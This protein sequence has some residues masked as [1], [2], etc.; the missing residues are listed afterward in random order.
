L[1]LQGSVGG[2]HKKRRTI[3]FPV[4]IVFLREK[5]RPQRGTDGDNIAPQATPHDQD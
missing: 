1:I 5:E 2:C 3:G 4:V